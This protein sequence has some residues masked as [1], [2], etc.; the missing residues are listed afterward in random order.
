[1]KKVSITF[2]GLALMFAS[3]KKDDGNGGGTTNLPQN[4][5]V[6]PYRVGTKI[7]MNSHQN[8]VLSILALGILGSWKAIFLKIVPSVG[9]TEAAW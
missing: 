9:S 5:L 1:M 4:C 6:S 8:A 2:L 3:C 7:T